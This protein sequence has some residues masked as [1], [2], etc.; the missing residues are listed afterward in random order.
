MKLVKK[1]D[2]YY[3]LDNLNRV[4]NLGITLE[5]KLDNI[6]IGSGWV[7]LS[8]QVIEP[9]ECE[10]IIEDNDFGINKFNDMKHRVAAYLIVNNVESNIPTAYKQAYNANKHL[11][12]Y[13]FVR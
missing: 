7:N 2:K 10:T 8:K 1:E 6:F 11:Y 5:D 4:A 9:Y 13:G 3:V 12:K